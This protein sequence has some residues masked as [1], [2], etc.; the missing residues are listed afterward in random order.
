MAQ[1]HN[2]V[3]AGI[4]DGICFGGGMMEEDSPNEKHDISLN[5]IIYSENFKSWFGNWEND[6][7]NASK[8]VDE[9]GR[10]LVV[11][12]GSPKFIGNKFD[13]RF[14]GQSGNYGESGLFCTTQ[15]KEWARRFS[16]PILPGSTSF[17][18]RLDKTKPGDILSGFLN[19]RHPL[20]LQHLTKNDLENIWKMTV[21][22]MHSVGMKKWGGKE[23]YDEWL[24]TTKRLLSIPNHQMIKFDIGKGG[25]IPLGDL[26]K[27]YGYDGFIARMDTTG[28]ALE[29]CFLY[30]NQFKSIKSAFSKESD[31][32]LDEETNLLNEATD[33]VPLLNLRMTDSN[34]YPFITFKKKDGTDTETFV[35]E[36]GEEHNTMPMK[37][38]TDKKINKEDFGESL[39]DIRR[40]EFKSGRI[41]FMDNMVVA[42]FYSYSRDNYKKMYHEISDTL[43][44]VRNEIGETFD[45][46][47]VVIDFWTFPK[48]E[49]NKVFIPVEW[50]K[51]GFADMFFKFMK[52]CV[53]F[54]DDTYNLMTNKGNFT[55]DWR[56][57]IVKDE[58]SESVGFSKKKTMVITESQ[59]RVMQVLL[60]SDD[61]IKK[62]NKI[63]DVAFSG[64]LNLDDKVSGSEY[65]V[66][67]DPATTWRKY[68][69]FSLRHTFG[70]MTNADVQYLPV[71]AR[72]A[73][74]DEVGFE[75]R[76]GN[77]R[78]IATLQKIVMY[79]KKDSALFNELKSNT[80]I[81]F[82]ELCERLEP[83]LKKHAAADLEAANSVETR[84]DYEIK[85]VP[86]FRTAKYYG[87]RTCS[88]SKLCYTQREG[89]W[90]NY[91]RNGARKVYVCLKDGWENVPE[92]PGPD[93]PYDEYGTSMIFVFIDENGDIAYSNCRWNHHTTGEY[94]GDV[95]HAFTKATLSQTVGVRFSDV[96][97]PYSREELHARGVVL[98]DE[99]QEMLDSGADPEDVFDYIGDF[100][101]GFAKV[102]LNDKWNFIN[103][104]GKLVSNQWFEGAGNFSEGF[105]AVALNDKWNFIN[106]EGKLVSN[107]WFYMV[108]RF[109]RE[110]F[111][112]VNLKDKGWN[113]IN[114]KGKLLSN[115]WFEGVYPFREGFA[116]VVSNK[117]WNFIN[118]EL[119]LLSNQWFDAVGN[120]SGGFAVVKLNGENYFIDTKGKLF[121]LNNQPLEQQTT[122]IQESKQSHS[123]NSLD[124][125]K[126]ISSIVDFLRSQY[127]NIDPLPDIELNNDEQE[128]LFIK[129]GYY[130][131]DEKKV[132]VFTNGRHIKDCLRSFV[133]EMVHHMQ[134]LQNHD[135]DWGG[136]G[137]LEEDGKL[138][139][140]E[141]EAFL[142]GNILFREWTEKMKKTNELNESKKRKK[143]VK[144]DK[145]EL[146]PETCDKCGGK[147]VCQIH[148]EPVYV[149]KDCG[150]YFGTMPFSDS[151]NEIT[152]EIVEPDD[153]DLSSFNIKKHLN[154]KFW[155]DGHLDTRIR[156]KLLDIADDFFES[157]DVDWVEPE[158]IIITGSLANYNWNKKY[159]DIDL[160][161]V[162]DYEDVDERVDF[163]RE[164]FTLKKNEW[165]RKHEGLKIY[166]FPVEVYVQDTNEPHASSGVYSIDRDEWITEPDRDRIL[167]GKVNKKR[168]R[169]IISTYMNKIDCLI[170]IY[171]HH[172][173]DKYE[174][175]RVSSDAS[176]ML[177]EIK[178]LRKDDLAKYGKEMCDGNIIF[179][180]LRRSDYIGKLIKLKNL[181]YNKI[182]SI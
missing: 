14:I 133:H 158:D 181:A 20:D 19:L 34:S 32:F 38:I 39:W 141:G 86:D 75:K 90:E 172:R 10:P 17:T 150:K 155:D 174:M 78:E 30:P 77:G 16:Y 136:G 3:N 63:M 56:G 37:L 40:N 15:D 144:N 130:L 83:V 73:F 162:I 107:Q 97:K 110:G 88:S 11:H 33:C 138:R 61:R 48:G 55:I 2:K 82:S 12:H 8:A 121:D 25:A 35:G 87:D 135:K 177:D 53:P 160:H 13:K 84:S 59:M 111:A 159:S 163:V 68:I 93:N 60:E 102:N 72:L 106:Q 96:F 140:I 169:E 139:N 64:L 165:N 100:S 182:N 156:L 74:S 127:L 49:H 95:D 103:Q 26:L 29:Y 31:S 69:L 109:S 125:Q 122:S 120:F 129:T 27:K 128:G 6:P 112:K 57:N 36:A 151:L 143:Q 50:L 46:G 58:V 152:S 92:E 24:N 1:V 9:N 85:E 168:V 5:D 176:E 179:K 18:I 108:C 116:R 164:Y 89:T 173:D 145:G 104:E 54:G 41:W 52:A 175:E 67:G 81:T 126:C 178:K 70:L 131:P 146:V 91:T 62:V 21:E 45:I 28:T 42:S 44:I 80:N 124:Y 123:N 94:H 4:M 99:V 166:G 147:V 148:G 153:V 154:H 66:N 71:V 23:D 170:D 7:D 65:Y 119:K 137:D 51:D 43:S 115:Q 101:E 161:I 118:H 180:S 167:S 157:L 149:C 113:F 22:Q 114:Q 98:L 132:V 134:N 79:L 117:K 76:N 105:G 142:L 171:K 47:K